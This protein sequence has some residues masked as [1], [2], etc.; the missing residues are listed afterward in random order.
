[1]LNSGFSEAT[2]GIIRLESIEGIILEKVCEYFYYYLRYKDEKEVPKPKIEPELALSLL[3]AAD[4]L[5][6]MQQR[7]VYANNSLTMSSPELLPSHRR[8]R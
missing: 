5:D 3:V 7:Y 8:S 1:M 4:F 2:S 6:G